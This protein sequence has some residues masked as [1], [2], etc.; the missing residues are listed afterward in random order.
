LGGLILKLLAVGICAVAVLLIPSVSEPVRV[1]RLT[2]EEQVSHAEM[3]VVG[4]LS[5]VEHDRL[6]MTYHR[7]YMSP[8]EIEGGK[9]EKDYQFYYNVGRIEVEEILKGPSDGQPIVVATYN[10]GTVAGQEVT[11]HDLEDVRVQEGARGIWLLNA[12]GPFRG[13][14]SVDQVPLSTDSLTAVNRVL[15]EVE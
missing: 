3:I 8:I 9:E 12:D 4:E 1:L 15:D 13:Y 11:W 10:R 14:Y 7:Y 6:S 2:L 5:D